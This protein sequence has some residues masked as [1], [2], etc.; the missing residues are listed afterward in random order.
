MTRRREINREQADVLAGLGH[1]IH[2]YYDPAEA[3]GRHSKSNGAVKVKTRNR[4]RSGGR[5]IGLTAQIISKNVRM[6]SPRAGEVYDVARTILKAQKG[7]PL[8]RRKLCEL[9]ASEL[10]VTEKAAQIQV[11]RLIKFKYLKVVDAA[12]K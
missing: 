12:N 6:T 9:I 1:K 2:Y 5:K 10:G 3:V 11:S 4:R 7:A 8:V